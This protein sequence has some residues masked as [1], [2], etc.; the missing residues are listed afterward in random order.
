LRKPTTRPLPGST[1]GARSSSENTATTAFT[2][3]HEFSKS[4]A[5]STALQHVKA[6]T[7]ILRSEE[8][9]LQEDNEE[10]E[11]FMTNLASK[12]SP[13]IF[14]FD[15]DAFDIAM[16]NCAS[17]TSTP[18]ENNLYENTPLLNVNLSGVGQSGCTF[19]GKARYEFI[20]DRGKTI[21]IDDHGVLVCPNLHSGVFSVPSWN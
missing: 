12:S 14:D 20:D 10:N 5:L 1:P 16:D 8:K 15:A 7:N 13:R 19:R 2:A 18:F 6:Y 3:H 11:L 21:I 17:R 4:L 9:Q